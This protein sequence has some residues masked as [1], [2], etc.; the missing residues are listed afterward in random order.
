MDARILETYLAN[1]WTRDKLTHDPPT[2]S[3]QGSQGSPVSQGSPASPARSIN[4]KLFRNVVLIDR[5]S[6]YTMQTLFSAAIS[7]M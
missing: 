6:V 7:K 4:A 3:T 2:H 5:E 1:H